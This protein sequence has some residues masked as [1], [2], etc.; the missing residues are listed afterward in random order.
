M[1]LLVLISG[2]DGWMVSAQDVGGE[3]NQ[4]QPP[5]F[6]ETGPTYSDNGYIISEPIQR[7]VLVA[8]ENLAKQSVQIPLDQ[9]VDLSVK[10]ASF[11]ITFVNAGGT[12]NWGEPCLAFPA[13]AMTA[14]NYA[15]NIWASNINS[16][17][18]ITIRACWANL[19]G[20]S[21]LG[22][23]GGYNIYRDFS[24]A[25][26]S[27]TWYASSLANSLYG[28]DLGPGVY[29]M[30][31]TYNTNF[32]WY[33]GTDANPT[34]GTM[35]FVTVAAH[36]LAH[37]LNFSGTAS[38]SSGIGSYG[39]DGYPSIYD[40][41]MRDGSG[42]LL[43]SFANP[44]TALGSLLT[45]NNLWFHGS[46]AMAANGS[47][48][49]KM[50]APTTWSNGSSYSH[51]DYD[52]FKTPNINSMMVYAISSG[53]ANHNPGPVTIGLLKDLGWNLAA[54]VPTSVTASD[55]TFTDKVV[56]SW[57]SA[58]NAT[59]YQVFR[60]TSNTTSGASTLSNNHS[61]SP[62]NDTTAVAGTLY[63]YWVKA[64]NTTGC[65]DYSPSDSGYRAASGL[66]P[67]TGV[68]ASDGTYNDKV[69]IS[70]NTSAGANHYQ[71]FR[72]TTDSFTGVVQLVDDQLE[73][74]FD[75]STAIVDTQYYYWVKACDDSICSDYSSFDTG[76]K[77]ST[78]VNP[79]TG[80]NASDGVYSDK[81]RIT[82]ITTAGADKYKV[83]RNTN[84]TTNGAYEF[85]DNILT[86]SFDDF[87][88]I[89]GSTYF[90]WVQACNNAGCS[91]YSASDSG[92]VQSMPT[93]WNVYLPILNK[94]Y[95]DV[96]P[97][98]NGDFELG[99]DGSWTEYSSNGWKLILNSEYPPDIYP[100]SGSWLTW[101]GGDDYETSRLSQSI[102][103]S[104][105]RPYLHFWYWIGSADTYCGYDFFRLKINNGEILK[106][107]LCTSTNTGGWRERVINL[108]AYNGTSVTLM[109]EVT[110]DFYLN[111]NFF[112][113]DVSMSSIPTTSAVFGDEMQVLGDVTRTRSK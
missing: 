57:D 52:T 76:Y 94:N 66:T 32:S 54:A 81:V 82:W 6:A 90:Y 42:I 108:S 84:N 71:V 44:S 28:S 25:P 4:Q 99:R 20:G 3:E 23:S 109:F 77:S 1:M 56:V 83:F 95:A 8:D 30:H 101:L 22:Y 15:T 79:P 41:Y 58:A 27:S 89:Q 18:P 88:A 105:T 112:L 35:D 100:H 65:S 51:L 34:A 59:Y 107:D 19:G 38:Y 106:L 60:N 75:D 73:S 97:I 68:E 33:F 13:N 10:G 69:R 16:N 40:R 86:N 21:I 98:K 62:F 39:W 55:G 64:C 43:T 5:Q 113:D 92:Y 26:V 9:N 103:I 48:R 63:Y 47:T 85:P 24:G 96:D 102:L 7:L 61:A 72:N 31:I 87:T 110:N 11:E 2:S 93:S 80:V 104:A 70:W 36:E 37:G 46:N 50:Y 91:D 45:S 49:V 78:A 14:F 67:P 111:S 17:V 74:P 29:D 53:T 12:D